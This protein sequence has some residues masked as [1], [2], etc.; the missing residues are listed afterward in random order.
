MSNPKVKVELVTI[1]ELEGYAR[2]SISKAGPTDHVPITLN[3]A[4]SQARNPNASPQDIALIVAKVG[5][6][7]GGYIG[8]I[9]ACLRIG[10]VKHKINWFTS[11]YVAESE[12]STGA[13][14]LLIMKAMSL[15]IDILVTGFTEQAE[16]IY[17]SAMKPMGSVQSIRVDRQQA[18]ATEP[19]PLF[20]KL[21]SKAKG[22]IRRVGPFSSQ[23]GSPHKSQPSDALE[24]RVLS[25]VCIE[26]VNAIKPEHQPECESRKTQSINAEFVR[27]LDTINWTIVNPWISQGCADESF[28]YGFD[29]SRSLFRYMPLAMY[30]T[31]TQRCLGYAVFLL[32][33]RWGRRM[34]QLFDHHIAPP[35]TCEVG[36]MLYGLTARIARE[37]DADLWELPQVC[38]ESIGNEKTTVNH[39]PYFYMAAGKL[40]PLL[41]VK[42]DIRLDFCDGDI[43]FG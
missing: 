12:R 35:N 23:Q 40:S 11:Y 8:L 38:V 9:P 21:I 4:I 13:G 33:E 5:E 10:N 19:R 15:K 17:R 36:Q 3:R 20:R 42:D 34:L 31:S 43:T 1:G 28:L 27:D 41:E 2:D 25:D 22:A 37:H 26:H 18:T 7:C 30:E 29:E 39:R 24:Q 14:A 32:T 6:R 16:Q